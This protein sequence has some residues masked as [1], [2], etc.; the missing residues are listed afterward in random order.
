MTQE[1]LLFLVIIIVGVIVLLSL[2]TLAILRFIQKRGRVVRS[3]NMTLFKV[4]LP[5]E[6]ES[7]E[8][9]GR[10]NAQ[11]TEQDVI[12]VM[13]QFYSSLSTLKTGFFKSLIY[14]QPFICFEIESK[15]GEEINFYVAIPARFSD[16][17]EKQIHGFFKNA[18]V[19]ETEDYTI[20][21]PQ[22][23]VSIGTLSLRKNYILPIKTYQ[24]LESDP[25]NSITNALS[26][27]T[28]N[29]G[30]AIQILIRPRQKP[31]RRKGIK[32]ARA[33]QQ[34]RNY[35]DVKPSNPLVKFFKFIAKGFSGV[36][37]KDKSTMGQEV[38]LTP[39]Q[40]E[41]VKALENKASKA[42]FDTIIRIITSAPTE[43]EAKSNLEHILSSFNQF[44]SPTANE[45]KIKQIGSK[46]RRKKLEFD[47][48][49]RN[50]N[51]EESM[52][53]NTEELT[54]IFHFP[55]ETTETPQI[56]RLESKEAPAPTQLPQEGLL[57]GYSKY[58]GV[59][60]EV[61]IKDVDRFRHIYMIGKTGSG[62]SVTLE[63][64]IIQDILEGKG[65]SVID[66][67]GELVESILGAV[68]K[69]RADDLILFDAGDTDRPL[70]LNLLEAFGDEQKEL[71]ALESMNIMLKLFG[72]EI[73]GPRLQDYFRN[74]TLTLMSDDSDPGTLIDIVRLFTDDNYQ[75]EKVA[76]IKN[77]VVKDFWTKQMA[78]TG[79]RE[80][81]EMIPFWAAKFGQFITNSTMRNILGQTKSAFDFRKVM[82]EGKILLVNLSKGKIGEINMQLLGM[83][84]VTKIQ[85]AALSRADI[86]EQQRKDFYL[87]VDEFQ[88]FATP[89]FES[90]LSEARKYHLSL[91]MAHQY[92]AQIKNVG[93]EYEKGLDL[94]AAVFGNVG[95][96]M[97]MRVGTE[98]AEFL[99]QEFAPAFTK[100]DIGNIGKYQAIMR[101][102][103]DN[104]S[105]KP[106]NVHLY[107]PYEDKNQEVGEAIRELARLKFGKPKAIV[108]ADILDRIRG[109]EEL[110]EQKPLRSP[111][112]PPLGSF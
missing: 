69:E 28:K 86:P 96:I 75:K 97:A 43:E 2:I 72:G 111:F 13:E 15:N 11:K 44:T 34:G 51:L 39:L 110:E 19:E 46:T 90:I 14:G 32:V 22:S 62:K 7:Q 79:Q 82:D 107:P 35:E 6:K 81:E 73:F 27:L 31:W 92:I 8:E 88:N 78:K 59:K 5:Y 84:M 17:V 25:L 68:P 109:L 67:H 9:Q 49:F 85:L 83:I 61:Y 57:L 18:V 71:V 66:P 54:S 80:K 103:I 23:K 16:L 55:V 50:F 64:M 101:L 100:R 36:G 94:S 89:A 4:Y 26:K 91:T 99:E 76:K 45:F 48:S 93:G 87:Y 105:S 77:P 42:G 3:L 40:E 10:A 104:T 56:Q 47:F 65:V 12:S 63:N 102:L 37:K 21:S 70:G 112:L 108:S 52:L 60:K 53:L 24:E 30:A 41:L 95:T 1:D 74:G 58:R 38:R 98:D 106:F 20:F 29:E 33:M